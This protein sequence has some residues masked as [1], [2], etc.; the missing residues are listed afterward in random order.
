MIHD[1]AMG[2]DV[3]FR[4]LINREPIRGYPARVIFKARVR[5]RCGCKNIAGPKAGDLLVWRSQ[6]VNRF[7]DHAHLVQSP[8]RSIVGILYADDAIASDDIPL[9]AWTG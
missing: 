6:L 7:G 2:A 3:I 8:V 4:L 9:E 5:F 1:V